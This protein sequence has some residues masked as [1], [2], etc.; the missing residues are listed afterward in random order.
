MAAVVPSLSDRELAD[1]VIADGAEWAFRELYNRHTPRVFQLILRLLSG[2]PSDA[3]DVLQEVWLHAV[4]GLPRFRWEAAFRTWLTSI[5]IAQ[6]QEWWRRR[7]VRV[8]EALDDDVAAAKDAAPAD[9]MDL[10]SAIAALPTGYRTILVLHDVEGFTHDEIATRLGI[11][12][13]TSKSQLFAARRALRARLTPANATT[14]AGER[15]C[16]PYLKTT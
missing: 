9:R 15:T 14:M 2:R 1:A 7:G 4:R 13:G 12:I 10:E 16:E 6:T 8:F 3:E 5:A 11:A